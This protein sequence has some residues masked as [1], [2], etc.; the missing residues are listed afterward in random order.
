MEVKT[1]PKKAYQLLQEV[2]KTTEATRFETATNMVRKIITNIVSN[3]NNDKFRN[4]KRTNKVLSEKLFIHQN[5]DELLKL[6]DFAYD[7][8]DGTYSYFEEDPSP[9]S[10]LLV[11]FDGFDVQIEAER[12]NRNVDPEKARERE[13]AVQKEMADKEKALRE[14]QDRIKCDRIDKEDEFKNRPVTDSKAKDRAFGAT[15]K[16]CKDILPPPG[17]K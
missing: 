17:R 1:R 10:S 3:P 8:A 14:L 7:D 5:I 15:V 13:L 16:H 2:Y 12:N 9:L 4:I 11:I 6:F